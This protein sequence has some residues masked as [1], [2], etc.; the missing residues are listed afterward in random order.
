VVAQPKALQLEESMEEV[1]LPRVSYA[2]WL[3]RPFGASTRVTS[4]GK[5]GSARSSLVSAPSAFRIRRGAP[6][7]SC[8]KSVVSPTSVRG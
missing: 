5:L 8:Q 1:T 2:A 6:Y 7:L 3:M 4:A